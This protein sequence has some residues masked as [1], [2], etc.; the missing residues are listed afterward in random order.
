M[1]SV[2]LI[3]RSWTDFCVFY[4]GGSL[5]NYEEHN[6][7]N[8]LSSEVAF[9]PDTSYYF[10]GNRNVFFFLG[11]GLYQVV[12][13]DSGQIITDQRAINGFL[14]STEKWLD[15]FGTDPQ[16]MTVRID[17]PMITDLVG[18]IPFALFLQDSS[19]PDKALSFVRRMTARSLLLPHIQLIDSLFQVCTTDEIVDPFS[20]LRI[21]TSTSGSNMQN[22]ILI[23]SE[24]KTLEDRYCSRIPG[25]EHIREGIRDALPTKLR[26]Q[27]SLLLAKSR[28]GNIAKEFVETGYPS[29]KQLLPGVND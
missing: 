10:S 12:F 19:S 1:L 16:L 3:I 2:L 22:S 8:I 21:L 17:E 15:T 13:E 20:P 9:L 18:E 24:M 26:Y 27:K 23:E 11:V 25:I 4:Q 5:E 29:L 6:R 7:I 28:I 14:V